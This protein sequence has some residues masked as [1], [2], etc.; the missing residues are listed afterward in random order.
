MSL[1]DGLMLEITVDC[2]SWSKKLPDYNH[3]ITSALETVIQKVHEGEA[4]TNF[5]YLELSV[6]LCDDKLIHQLNRDY[7][8]QDKATNVLSFEGLD[9]EQRDQFL[10]LKEDVPAHPFSLGE[11]YIAFETMNEEAMA[12]GISLKDHFYHLTIHGILHL[13]GYDH[14]EDEE[15]EVMEKLETSLLHHLGIDDPYAA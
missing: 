11:I 12:A 5:T 10:R 3:I 2:E 13:L 14:M 9:M 8:E 7:R 4:I 1:P 15:A 6:V